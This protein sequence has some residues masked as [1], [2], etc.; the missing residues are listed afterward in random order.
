MKNFTN[1]Y[2]GLFSYIW[3][4][5]I[6]LVSMNLPIKGLNSSLGTFLIP[7]AAFS[8]LVFTIL[9]RRQLVLGREIIFVS[10]T[11]AIL[12]F[13]LLFNGLFFGGEYW[14][15]Y[16][17]SM[18]A[19]PFIP[20]A[21]YLLARN[22]CIGSRVID[23]FLIIAVIGA[24]ITLFFSFGEVKR[25]YGM[26]TN[27]NS[28]AATLALAFTVLMQKFSDSRT[29]PSML[30]MSVLIF[31][32]GLAVLMTASRTG[33]VMVLIVI[34]MSLFISSRSRVLALSGLLFACIYLM[35]NDGYIVSRFLSFYEY[36]VSGETRLPG[37]NSLLMRLEGYQ[38]GYQLFRDNML[39]GVGLG[40]SKDL[41][42]GYYGTKVGVHNIYMLVLSETGVIGMMCLLFFFISIYGV[43]GKY[44]PITLIVNN[45]V[46]V[47]LVDGVWL[48]VGFFQM[49]FYGATTL[50]IFNKLFWVWSSFLV[51]GLA[52]N[53]IR[54]NEVNCL[55]GRHEKV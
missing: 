45:G 17:K 42:I 15:D 8:F 49:L 55:G 4:G 48:K 30:L 38:Y 25:A 53:Y 21:T 13:Y 51:L 29:V 40:A 10:V 37:Q 35:Y 36:F 39:W 6:G 18:V 1:R 43:I 46:G 52:L 47:K 12:F 2:Y 23:G 33:L 14:V 54:N 22:G 27:A 9:V 32:V 16:I 7:I 3:G 20:L 11:Y 41:L 50:L 19:L 24:F 31:L 28:T 44:M 34:S 26:T 5:I